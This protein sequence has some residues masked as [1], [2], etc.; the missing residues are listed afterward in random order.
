MPFPHFNPLQGTRVGTPSYLGRSLYEAEHQQKT[1][2][3]GNLYPLSATNSQHG[4]H[5]QT[6]GCKSCSAPKR[7]VRNP[8]PSG[9]CK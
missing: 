4:H 5:A 7:D 9:Q 6:V 8:C 2:H 1:G 3:A